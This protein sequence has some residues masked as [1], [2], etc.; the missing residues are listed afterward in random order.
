M[1]YPALV[2]AALIAVAGFIVPASAAPFEVVADTDTSC[3]LTP[4][5]HSVLGVANDTVD[6]SFGHDL[7]A[8]STRPPFE[9]VPDH[10][11]ADAIWGTIDFDQT[12]IDNF[13]TPALAREQADKATLVVAM[14]GQPH[15]VGFQRGPEDFQ[16]VIYDCVNRLCSSYGCVRDS[17]RLD[18]IHY[19]AKGKLATN[20][21][22]EIR[23]R[24]KYGNDDLYMQCTSLI[25]AAAAA[26]QVQISDNTPNCYQPDING[27][28]A[29]PAKKF[30]SVGEFVFAEIQ[31]HDRGGMIG[32]NIRFNG[33]TTDKR[34]K[35]QPSVSPLAKYI[36]KNILPTL[37]QVMKRDDMSSRAVCGVALNWARSGWRP[38]G[39]P[40]GV[41]SS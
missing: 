3:K 9:I 7:P 5:S 10:G 26:Y 28:R 22:I 4:W 11:E 21:Y 36:S 40:W 37:E 23:A 8:N 20:A 32:V 19:N 13:T 18:S 34:H 39:T 31:N 27:F 1:R 38:S 16:N 29:A 6:T 35:C 41:S 30:C 2:S 12:P 14:W 24:G 15:H 25:S 17:C 33:K